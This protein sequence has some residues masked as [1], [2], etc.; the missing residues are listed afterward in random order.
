[1][2]VVQPSHIQLVTATLLGR[3]TH[4]VQERLSFDQR[5]NALEIIFPSSLLSFRLP[6]SLAGNFLSNMN[7]PGQTSSCPA[8]PRCRNV[9]R[10]RS[11][12]GA[13]NNNIFTD[14]GLTNTA[15]RR[16]IAASYSDGVSEPRVSVVEG[17]AL[18]NARVLSTILYPE[19][20]VPDEVNTLAVMQFG[21]LIS[22]DT[23]LSPDQQSLMT[24]STLK[25]CG[26]NGEVITSSDA[27]EACISIDVPVN[28]S[29]YSQFNVRCLNV[30]RSMTTLNKKCR[31]GPAEQF[32]AVTH[33]LDASFVYGSEQLLADS[34]RL[35][36]GGLL[37]TQKTKDGRHFMPNSKEPTKD[38]D[39]DSDDSVCYEAGDGR[40]N[41]HPGV[42]IIHTL[43]LR[44]HNRI[45]GILQGLNISLGRR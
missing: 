1:M 29:F 17:R 40:V 2:I 24:N 14:W 26:E 38:C 3:W 41:Q 45:A 42:A 33:F 8:M 23:A 34:L 31:L 7:I 4:T 30:V 32:S 18:P 10:F 35:R 19:K 9:S 12:D 11:I 15:L 39:V 5:S 25:C 16:L 13:C 37:K 36:Q 21:Q 22:H 43:F 44:E 6:P 27:N 28:D 20:D